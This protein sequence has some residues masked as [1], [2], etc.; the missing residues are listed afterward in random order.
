[1]KF[2]ETYRTVV[3][4]SDCDHLGHMNV[5]RYF[6]ACSDGVIT[7][8]TELGLGPEDVRSGRQ[9]SFAVVRAESDFKSEVT[10]G[11]VIFLKTG[12][13][14]IGGKSMIFCHQLVRAEN[15]QIVFETIFRCVLLDLN[16]RKAVLIPDDIRKKAETFLP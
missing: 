13:Q 14:E 12:V 5:S 6:A 16:S 9:L 8:Q 15:D 1:L 11:E 3:A 4:P 10:A 2:R 7:F